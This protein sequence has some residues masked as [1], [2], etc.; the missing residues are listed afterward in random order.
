MDY[1]LLILAERGGLLLYKSEHLFQIFLILLH[2]IG[3]FHDDVY[4]KATPCD[5][6]VGVCSIAVT[7][8]WYISPI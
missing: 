7:D 8:K 1:T 6:C 2:L 3:N 4:L 5:S